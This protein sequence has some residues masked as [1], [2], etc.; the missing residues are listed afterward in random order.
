MASG[1]GLRRIAAVALIGIAEL[2]TV[3]AIA[4]VTAM[5]ASAQLFD[6]RFPFLEERARRQQQH[7]NFFNPFAPPPEAR[8]SPTVD[9]SRAP[10]PRKLDGTPLTS[11]VV[12]GDAMADW[13]AYGLEIAAS[14]SPDIGI[15]RRHRT[16]SGLIRAEVKN[17]PRGD[18]PDWPQAAR[19]ILTQEKANFVVFMIGLN[20]RRPIRDKPPEK[21]PLRGA[22]P[23]APAQQSNQAP[24]NPSAP[25]AKPADAAIEDTEAPPGSEPTPIMV[26]REA[27]PTG[28]TL[29]EFRSE[30]WVELYIKRIDDTIAALKSRNV[31]VFWVGLPPIRGTKAS[32]DAG[33]LNDLYRSRA[34]K[35]GITYIDVWDGFVDE[36]GRFVNYGPDFEGQTRR[37]RAADGVYFTQAGARKL[38]HYVEREI[39]RGLMALAVPVALPAPEEPAPPVA[40]ARP[41]NATIARPLAGPVMP[42]TAAAEADELLGGGSARQAAAD[43]IAARV[44]MRGEQANAPAGR[45]DDFAWPRR[46][47][48]PLG[49]DPVVATT[50]T[51]MTPM[52][53]EQ[54]QAAAAPG[55]GAAAA[56]PPARPAGPTRQAAS[57]LRPPGIVGQQRPEPRRVAPAPQPFFFPFFGR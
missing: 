23:A 39:Q 52:Q 43:P 57:A 34:E 42:L 14:E 29:H 54:R 53:T 11:V 40:A 16:I 30:K 25:G 15:L 49:T 7:N 24:A 33:F 9:Y 35:A 48:A 18:H 37:L 47:V 36:A 2:A 19:D 22:Q 46:S 5:P 27:T 10:A 8:P 20:D 41:G 12:M 4:V 26:E 56:P 55:V 31:P 44:L 45:A 21:P 1:S 28:T 32:S 50:T 17:D 13:L 3:L 6:D 51:P 38:A